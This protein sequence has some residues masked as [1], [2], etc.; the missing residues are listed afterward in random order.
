MPMQPTAAL[1]VDSVRNCWSAGEGCWV[2]WILKISRILADSSTCGAA[3][4]ENTADSET[5]I[6]IGKCEIWNVNSKFVFE[7]LN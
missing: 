4:C 2:P 7:F 6:N 3:D 1:F 5:E